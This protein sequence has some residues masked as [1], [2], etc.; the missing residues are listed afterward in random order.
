MFSV[1]DWV[2]VLSPVEIQATLDAD[3]AFEHLPFMPE[4]LRPV[5]AATG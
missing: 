3:S 4:M 5:A 1:G 2:E